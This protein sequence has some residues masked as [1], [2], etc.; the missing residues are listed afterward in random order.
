MCQHL[1]PPFRLTLCKAFYYKPLWFG[2][3]YAY[4]QVVIGG[5]APY[6]TRCLHVDKMFF[7]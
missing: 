2:Y 7:L 3:N 1:K 5:E 4:L 6:A